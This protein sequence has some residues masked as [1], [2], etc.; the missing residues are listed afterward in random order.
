MCTQYL[1][2]IHP[3][4]PLPNLLSLPTGTN[5]PNPRQDL[6][7]PPV[8]QFCLIKIAT[9]EASLWHFHVY[10]YYN[11]SWFIS[12]FFFLPYIFDFNVS[13]LYYYE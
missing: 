3:P 4:M 10:K 9:Q 1:H 11:T 2:Y 13:T 7:C 8:L 12:I 6:L 5:P